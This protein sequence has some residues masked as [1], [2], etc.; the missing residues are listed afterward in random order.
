MTAHFSL[1]DQGLSS[2]CYSSRSCCA[3]SCQ[4]DLFKK[5]LRLHHFKWYQNE[6]WQD[7]P[8]S[9]CASIDKVGFWIRH[10]AFKIAVVTL[11]HEKVEGS[12]VSNRIWIKFS[13]NVF[14]AN[15]S[16]SFDSM[17]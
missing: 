11:F 5:S 6:I 16:R 1:L 7:C 13:T 2:N 4:G 3:S 12:V 15:T 8:S 17:S 14:Q 10:H 9:E